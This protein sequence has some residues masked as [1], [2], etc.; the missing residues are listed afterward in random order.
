MDINQTDVRS[1]TALHWAVYEGNEVAVTYLISWGANINAQDNAGNTPLH[2][3]VVY[4]LKDQ[5]IVI[6]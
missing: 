5:N 4:A 2:L 6:K 3:S 1:S